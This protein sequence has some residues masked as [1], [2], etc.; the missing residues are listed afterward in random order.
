MPKVCLEK[1]DMTDIPVSL[2]MIRNE[3][4][5][6]SLSYC[7]ANGLSKLVKGTAALPVGKPG[8]GSFIN[9]V[10]CTVLKFIL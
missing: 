4:C 9:K 10:F 8:S 2:G 6:P 3:T 7:S 1:W 5:R